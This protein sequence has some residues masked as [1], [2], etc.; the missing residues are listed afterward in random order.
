MLSKLRKSRLG[1]Y[2]DS[3]VTIM[4]FRI[5][6]RGDVYRECGDCKGARSDAICNNITENYDLNQ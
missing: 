4:Y 3:R 1:S 2:H 5:A 6:F